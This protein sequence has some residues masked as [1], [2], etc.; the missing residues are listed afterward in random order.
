MTKT[1]SRSS[2]VRSTG[3]RTQETQ[4]SLLHIWMPSKM[5]HPSDTWRRPSSLKTTRRCSA[6]SKKSLE[7]TSQ[8]GR[9]ITP[10]ILSKHIESSTNSS[11]TN[12]EL[13]K[14]TFPKGN[15]SLSLREVKQAGVTPTMPTESVTFVAGKA[16]PNTHAQ[17]VRTTRRQLHQPIY[18]ENLPANN[19]Q[20]NSSHRT[21]TLRGN[22][23]CHH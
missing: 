7:M 15:R 13:N 19:L 5:R 12:Q 17:H 3:F 9:T 23:Q 1:S 14:E 20:R 11:T 8:R 21:G 16:G 4:G 2:R 18:R 22:P 10:S 6:S